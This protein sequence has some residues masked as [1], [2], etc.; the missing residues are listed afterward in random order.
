ME[1]VELDAVDT[2]KVRRVI[3]MPACEARVIQSRRI[4][5]IIVRTCVDATLPL[6]MEDMRA[7]NDMLCLD[8]FVYY[9][10]DFKYGCNL[11]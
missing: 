6:V 2:P 4:S 11:K 5:H 8:I 9:G 1:A 10:S 3:K 7:G